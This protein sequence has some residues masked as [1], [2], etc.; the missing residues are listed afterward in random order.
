MTILYLIVL[1]VEV[2]VKVL[3]TVMNLVLET[4][5]SMLNE[6]G[7]RMVAISKNLDASSLTVDTNKV[8]CK[9]ASFSFF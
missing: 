2:L 6:Y 5:S 8:V 4:P 1:E 9:S 7:D 3:V